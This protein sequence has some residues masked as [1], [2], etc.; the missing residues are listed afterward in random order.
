MGTNLAAYAFLAWVV[1]LVYRAYIANKN[2]IGAAE[3]AETGIKDLHEKIDKILDVNVFLCRNCI[4]LR[5]GTVTTNR[6]GSAD[7]CTYT[8]ARYQNQTVPVTHKG[9][10]LLLEMRLPQYLRDNGFERPSFSK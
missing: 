9:D 2:N 4:H 7:V 1:W 3:R 10:S 5:P 8:C 6:D